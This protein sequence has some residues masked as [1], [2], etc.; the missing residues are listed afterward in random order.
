MNDDWKQIGL[1]GTDDQFLGEMIDGY[2]EMM[3]RTA[4]VLFKVTEE[5]QRVLA[6]AI[7]MADSIRILTGC[8]E[9]FI[10]AVR[11]ASAIARS[12]KK[13]LSSVTGAA[14]VT[15][16]IEKGGENYGNY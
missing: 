12:L 3:F 1:G 9:T 13:R 11:S 16:P 4:R 8:G 15:N 7:T 10:P 5:G 6:K 14:G 2:R